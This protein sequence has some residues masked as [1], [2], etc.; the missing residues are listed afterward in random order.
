MDAVAV[1]ALINRQFGK[2]LSIA[3]V[4]RLMK[5]LGFSA[6]TAPSGLA[7][8]R[9]AGAAREAE[10]YP[11]SAPKRVQRVRRSTSPTSRVSVPITTL[12]R[13]GRRAGKPPWLSSP[14]AEGGPGMMGWTRAA[15]APHLSLPT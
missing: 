14:A 13:R 7:T 5:V 9:C 2:T 4:S 6:K 3:T 8:G 1:R 10:T 11:Q 15:A 12:A